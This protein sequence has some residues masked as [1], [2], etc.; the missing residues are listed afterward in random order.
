VSSILGDRRHRLTVAILLERSRP[1]TI[2][3][4]GVRLAAREADVP[5]ADVTAAESRS[6][7]VD[8]EHRCLPK[9]EAVGWIERRSEGVV[10]AEP[11]SLGI[12]ALSL[13]DFRDP[14]HPSWDAIGVLL[15]RPRR[16]DL[17]AILAD[18]RH[19]LSL[20]D[21]IAELRSSSHRDWPDDDRTLSTTLHHV[22]LPALAAAGL[23]EYDAD[24]GMV[25]RTRRLLTFVERTAFDTDALELASG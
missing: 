20:D 15:A 17:V 12:E 16:L 8:L 6:I 7:R 10:A 18:R 24:D 3:D 23:I 14:D 4:L 5:P 13:P 9:L 2:H 19:P 25:A 1:T 11:P 22:D 21:L